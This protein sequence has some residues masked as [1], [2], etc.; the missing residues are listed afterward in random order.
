MKIKFFTDKSFNNKKVTP[1]DI[2]N[3][4]MNSVGAEIADRVGN[5]NKDKNTQSVF[6]YPKPRPRSFEIVSYLNDLEALAELEVALVG[7]TFNLAGKDIL[8]TDCKWENEGFNS[9]KQDLTMYQTRTP[10]VITSN[11]VEHKIVYSSSRANNGSFEEYVTKKIKEMI[12]IQVKEFFKQ[13]IDL[14]DLSIKLLDFNKVT[15]NVDTKRDK[16]EQAIYASFISN[17]KL[18]RF[19]GF[20]NGLGYGEIYDNATRYKIADTKLRKTKKV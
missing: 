1:R 10:I 7:K 16:Y 14:S 9:L 6:V 3:I 17:Y 4:M 12:E 5:K 15:V 18:P 8:I 13:D 11:V 20:K 19:I 2:R